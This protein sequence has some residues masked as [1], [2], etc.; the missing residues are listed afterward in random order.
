MEYTAMA[1]GGS[2]VVLSKGVADWLVTRGVVA[3][4][5]VSQL[6]DG[7]S[8]V[9]DDQTSARFESGAVRRGCE[10]T[11]RPPDVPAC[12]A[13]RPRLSTCRWTA[14]GHVVPTCVC[15]SRGPG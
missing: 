9:L 15:E 5:S 14:S 2:S 3:R 8:V 12:R 13:G 10:L 1:A 11:N 6:D 7:E 4:A